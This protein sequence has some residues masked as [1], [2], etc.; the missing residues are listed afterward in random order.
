MEAQANLMLKTKSALV[1]SL[2]EMKGICDNEAKERVS[3]LS[4][5]R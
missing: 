2:D 4:K 1:A 3:L 5:Y